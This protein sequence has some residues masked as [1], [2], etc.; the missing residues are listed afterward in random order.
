M[1]SRHWKTNKTNV[2]LVFERKTKKNHVFFWF[3]LFPDPKI[4]LKTLANF[5]FSFKNQKKHMVLLVF[6]RRDTMKTKKTH[7]IFLVF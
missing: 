3:S 5:G 6:Q 1:V 4:L 7:G 2:F